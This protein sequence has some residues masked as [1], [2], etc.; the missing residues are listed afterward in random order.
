MSKEI[1]FILNQ[2]I[3]KINDIDPNT[4]VLNYLRDKK[5]LRGTKEGCASGDCGACTAVIA[6]LIN[7]K[8]VYKSI[9]TCIMFI[10]N[11]HGKQLITV[12]HLKDGTKLHPVQKSM[13]DYGGSQCGFCTP[14]FIMSMFSMYKNKVTTTKKN[15]DEQLAGNLCR[16]TG[17]KPIFTATKNMN[18]YGK[19]DHFSK[20]EKKIINKLKSIKKNNVAIRY[21]DKEFFIPSDLN[22]LKENINEIE[23][24]KFL[25]GGTDL[26]LEVTKKRK[27]IESFIFLGNNSDLKYIKVVDNKILIGGATPIND[28]INILKKYYPAIADMYLRYGSSQIRNVAT[29]GGNIANA[30]PIGDSAP[31]LISL[32][33]SVIIEGNKTKIIKLKD[34]FISYKKTV[35]EKNEFLKEIIIPIDKNSIFKCYK[36]SKRFDD[37]ISAVFMAINLKQKNQIINKISITLGGMAE[38]PKKAINTEKFL[39]RKKF[40]YKNIIKAKEYLSEDFT[41][42]NDMRASKKYRKII[43]QNL[44]EK[45][46]Y[47]ISNNKT[48]SVN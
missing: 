41:P 34:F 38:V 17:Y 46:Y 19:S 12:E 22:N 11:L 31:A 23:N 18:K 15:I 32:D 27:S 1:S 25:S 14:G 8:L 24:F 26:A 44:L 13:V 39:N 45:F 40:N 9:N 47:E 36:I 42:I 28:T 4:T 10:Y 48:I 5:N 30:S 6:E 33:S 21:L 43:S 37:D 20:I 3:I 2:D 29:I 35:L 16:C 7:D